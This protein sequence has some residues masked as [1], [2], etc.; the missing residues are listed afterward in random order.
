M[1]RVYFLLIILGLL[2]AS[3]YLTTTLA[4]GYG[5]IESNVIARY[6]ISKNALH[7]YKLVGIGLL[8][9]YLIWSAK[10]DLKSQLI[11]TRL[12]TWANISFGVIVILN[13]GTCF[14]Q[15]NM[16]VLIK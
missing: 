4:L 15:R 5:A 2:N 6:F 1:K 12:L 10:K 16:P 8:S 3:D 9:I 7:Y 13:I 14:F 11:I